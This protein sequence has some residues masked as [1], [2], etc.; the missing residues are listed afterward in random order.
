[1]NDLPDL[2]LGH[3]KFMAEALGFDSSQITLRLRNLTSY[4]H[5]K[6]SPHL[7]DAIVAFH[8]LHRG[9][10]VDPAHLV[11][12]NGAS[13][14]LG[15]SLRAWQAFTAVVIPP[16]WPGLPD[17]VKGAGLPLTLRTGTFASDGRDVIITT[18]PNNPTGTLTGYPNDIWDAA[19]AWPWYT[20]RGFCP[21]WD[22]H[23]RVSIFTASKAVG[24]A[25]ARI[26]WAIIPNSELRQSI[27]DEIEV[28]TG[29]V[30]LV[31]QEFTA[32]ALAAF[33]TYKASKAK[34]TLESRWHKV[35]AVLN[36]NRYEQLSWQGMFLLVKCIA[37]EAHVLPAQGLRGPAMGLTQEHV[38][39]NIGCSTEEF[40]QFVLNMAKE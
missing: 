20:N 4:D 33:D 31:A 38:R 37:D 27:V 5:T 36:R 7:K 13:Q 9:E 15:A 21:P 8:K 34:N 23:T 30:S 22:R 3:P 2:R 10:N 17:I 26:G 24:L 6:I 16:Y 32:N 11:V 1:M 35:E 28:Q 25:S 39:F 40:E 19:Y 12:G 18:S 14:L 29:G